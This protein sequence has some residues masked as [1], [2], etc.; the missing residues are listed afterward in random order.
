M[1]LIAFALNASAHWPLVI[2]A[3]RDEFW[4]RPTLPLQ[5][6]TAPNGVEVVCGRDLQA[7]GTWLGATPTGRVAMLTNVREGQ[8]MP[9]PRSRG[10][11][12]LAWLSGDSAAPEFLARL[13]ADGA[14]QSYGGFNLVIGDTRRGEWMWASNRQGGVQGSV[15]GAGPLRPSWQSRQLGP[16]VYG[17]SNAF[18]DTPWPKT[19]ALKTAL[20]QALQAQNEA[21]LAAPL[22]NALANPGLAAVAEL[23]QTGVPTD[24]ERVLSSAFVSYPERGYGTRCSTL[25][26][27]HPH[28]ETQAGH[29]VQMT[30]KSTAP[31]ESAPDAGAELISV[32][33][34]LW[35]PS[36]WRP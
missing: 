36:V 7:G 28:D 18:L 13:Q 6:W 29:P 20:T 5:R 8:P 27:M 2:V 16:G 33:H 12:P 32:Q 26:F 15:Q 17:L 23:P 9:A 24:W 3:N 22:W 25:L 31:Q 34:L 10:D 30:E 21:E 11:L 4:H 35:R 19:E 14:E 1:C